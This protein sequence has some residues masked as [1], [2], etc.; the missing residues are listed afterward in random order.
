MGS[1]M[2]IRDRTQ[3][4]QVLHDMCVMAQAD[5][6]VDAAERAVLEEVAKGLGVPSSFVCQV[7]DA[8]K[9]LD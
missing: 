5:G 7:V 6:G 1:E 9:E 4:M 2:C 8:D 3:C